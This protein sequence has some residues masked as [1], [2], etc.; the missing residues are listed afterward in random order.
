MK[1]SPW[2]ARGPS[3]SAET[4]KKRVSSGAVSPPSALTG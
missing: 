4:T 2:F 3:M 1:H